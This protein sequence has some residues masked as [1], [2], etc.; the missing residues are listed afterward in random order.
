VTFD[1]PLALLLLVLVPVLGALY[2][3]LDRRRRSQVARFGNPALVAGLLPARPTRKRHVPIVVMLVA[4]AALIVGVARPHAT[5]SVPREEATIMLALDT[6]L[7]M[8]ATDVKPNRLAAATKAIEGLLE[9]A[10][11]SVRVGLVSFS[12]Q[13]QVILSPTSDREAAAAALR[14]IRLGRGTAIGSAILKALGAVRPLPQ[15]G[16]PP[17]KVENPIPATIVLLSD[18]A[19]TG[20]GPAPLAAA[21][22]AKEAGVPVNT[23]ALG[24]SDAVVEVP[25]AGGLKERVTVAPD[26]EALEA[27]AKEGNGKYYPVTDAAKLAEIYRDLGSRMGRTR[28]DREITAAFAGGGA[29]LALVAGGLSMAW[30]RRPL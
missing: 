9:K 21:R 25:L 28:Q 16:Q 17:V 30:F 23:V 19:Q 26:R 10:P 13:S 29:L 2:V 22:Q 14:E 8:S 7:S 27:V 12:D 5:L 24:T 1:W 18:G 11:S 6:S 3:E 15:Q 20:S 4:I